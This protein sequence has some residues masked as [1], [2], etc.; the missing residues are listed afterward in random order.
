M[1]YKVPQNKEAF[2]QKL[3]ETHERTDYFNKWVL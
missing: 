3:S 2:L 1:A